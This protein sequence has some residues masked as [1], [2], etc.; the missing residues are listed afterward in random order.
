MIYSAPK[1]TLSKP[2]NNKV[3]IWNI[4]YIAY[5]LKYDAFPVRISEGIDK[6]E[7]AMKYEINRKVEEM[8]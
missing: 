8:E 7:L 2:Y 4:G 1:I 6:E 3:G 5:M